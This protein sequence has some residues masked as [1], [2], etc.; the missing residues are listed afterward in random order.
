MVNVGDKA[1]DFALP[2]QDGKELKL[3]DFKDSNVILAF[4]PFDFSPVCT[5][6]FGCFQDDLSELNDLNA[7]V[8]GISV[9]SKYCHKEFADKLKLNFTL[10]S[11][12]G[13]EVCKLYGTL[14]KEGFSERAYFI[15]DSQGIVRFKYFMPNPGERLENRHLIW[16]LKK[17]RG[18]E[19]SGVPLD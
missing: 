9:D 16:D 18:T 8:L 6:E 19:Q 2:D 11:D 15:I 17:I 1:P 5:V 13:K 7:K 4:Y 3:S 12:F 10:L 14:R